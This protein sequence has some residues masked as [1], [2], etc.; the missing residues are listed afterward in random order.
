MNLECFA[1]W[2]SKAMA[3]LPPFFMPNAA[4]ALRVFTDCVND[5]AHQWG[6]HPEDYTLFFVGRFDTLLGSFKQEHIDAVASGVSCKEARVS[7]AQLDM[8]DKAGR[9]S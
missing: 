2:D 6:R 5:P 4:M 1:V 9:Q 3:Y 8:L 7:A